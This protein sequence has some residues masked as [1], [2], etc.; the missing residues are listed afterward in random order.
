MVLTDMPVEKRAI[1]EVQAPCT[2]PQPCQSQHAVVRAA[3]NLLSA[4]VP[5]NVAMETGLDLPV[6]KRAISEAQAP[7]TAP[8]LDVRA[9]GSSAS[10][11]LDPSAMQFIW[12]DPNLVHKGLLRPDLDHDWASVQAVQAGGAGP[13]CEA[14][15]GLWGHVLPVTSKASHHADLLPFSLTPDD[16]GGGLPAPARPLLRASSLKDKIILTPSGP[17]IDKVLPAPAQPLLPREIFTPEYFSS[18]HNLVAAAGIRADGSTY[19]ALTPNYMG[20]R[21]RLEHVGLKIDRW[22]YHL[23]G[24]EHADILQHVEFGF[25]LGLVDFPELKSCSRNHGSSYGFFTHV[26]KFVSEEIQLGGLAG[27]FEKVPWWDTVL[28]PLMTAPKKP[29]SRRTVYDASFG[30][31]SLNNSTPGEFYLGQPCVYT[32]P[33]IDDFR[34]LVLRCG[35]GSFMFK[36]DLSR[37]FLQIPLDPVEYHRV[38][39]LWRGLFFFF[40]GLA[41]GLRHSGLQGQR[42]T[43]ALSWIHRRLGLETA[44]GEQFNVVNYSD[45]L[46]GCETELL[47]AEESFTKLKQLM[48]DLG[49]EEST[50]KAEAP[51]NQLVYLGVMFDSILM[52]MRV[53]PEKLSEIKSEIGQWSRK[54]TITRRN[55]QSL[56]G[57]LFWVSRV[58]RLA[59]VFMGRLLQQLR[60]MA[61]IGENVKVKLSEDSRKDLKWWARYLEHFNGIQMI[62]EED[63][64]PL[65]LSQLLDRPFEVYAGDAT[66]VG[67][68]GWFGDQYWSR[69]LPRDLQD[70]Q[71]PIHVK[72]FWCL[73]VSA[74]LWGKNWTGRAITLFCDNC[75]VVDTINHKKPRDPALLSLLREFLY[76]AVSFK[77]FPVVRKISTTDNY[78]ADHISRRH[79]HTAAAKLFHEAGLPPMVEVEVPDLSFKLTDAW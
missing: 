71:L 15:Y 66:P 10:H 29:S 75:S 68:G 62:M 9:A 22:R 63:P 34:R 35:P 45:D 79:D 8:Q 11:I 57:K 5:Q 23:R 42:L 24:Y 36:R 41:F 47:R 64:F 39:M 55:L 37:F 20:A 3:V 60:T 70:P 50:K 67:G 2:A 33:K 6:E 32:Y 13:Q 51:A 38:G 25:P 18:L 58:V 27:P 40:I 76:I 44:N 59:R 48:D 74:R 46:G 16:L 26:D 28:S 56:L 31:F 1:M 7:C 43:D 4:S 17:F 12:R 72:E 19:P 30:D 14:D 61:N 77:F 54:T 52:Q 69:M 78:L 65:E 53:P 49:L 21:I 73:I